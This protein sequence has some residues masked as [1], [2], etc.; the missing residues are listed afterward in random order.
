M[1]IFCI[2]P[3][4]LS[5]KANI[6]TIFLGRSIIITILYVKIDLFFSMYISAYIKYKSKNIYNKIST[7]SSRYFDK[8]L[9]SFKMFN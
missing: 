9:I 4:S 8:K 1:C 5:N 3:I 2:A 7:I 6:R